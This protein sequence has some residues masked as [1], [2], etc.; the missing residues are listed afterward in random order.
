MFGTTGEYYRDITR[1][2]FAQLAAAGK[3]KE[4]GRID[5]KGIPDYDP[6]TASDGLMDGINVGDAV[7]TMTYG[8]TA[9]VKGLYV[10]FTG[11]NAMS[12]GSFSGENLLRHGQVDN[13]TRGSFST[14][15][16]RFIWRV[17]L[18]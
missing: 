3:L 8:V 16:Q 10:Y 18:P 7:G 4:G 14:T 13:P 12:L 9:E 15:Y 2:G 6:V 17:P 5:I 11:E 1:R